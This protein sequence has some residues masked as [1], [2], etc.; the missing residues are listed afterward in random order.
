[1]ASHAENCLVCGAGLVYSSNATTAACHLCGAQHETNA[2]CNNNHY[3]CD[4]CHAAEGVRFIGQHASDTSSKNPV[5]IALEMMR[6]PGIKMHGPEHH[7]LVVAALLAAYRNAGGVADLARALEN[8]EQRAKK[9]PGGICGL[10]GSCGAGIGTGIFISLVTGATPLSGNEWS[11]ANTMTSRC[12]G[13]IAKHGGPR[14][15]KRNTWLA[16]LQAVAFVG[17]HF[18]IIMEIPETIVCEF[19]HRNKQ[20]RNSA[21]LFF[22]DNSTRNILTTKQ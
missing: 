9:V 1:M 4:A 19:S 12:L 18:K 8:A 11:L 21:C 15:C 3:V 7:Y 14:C 20:C 10:W 17:E 5:A 22:A 6:H 16:L 13:V 2:L